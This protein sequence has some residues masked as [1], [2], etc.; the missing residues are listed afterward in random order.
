MNISQWR[1]EDIR[2]LRKVSI[3]AMD[4]HYHMAWFHHKRRGRQTFGPSKRLWQ[5]SKKMVFPLWASPSTRRHVVHPLWL[6]GRS[7]GQIWTWLEMS[8]Q[9]ASSIMGHSTIGK[10]YNI[11]PGVMA[12]C[13]RV[14]E[15]GSLTILCIRVWTPAS[16]D[17]TLWLN[18][19]T[20][21]VNSNCLQRWSL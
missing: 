9:P 5:H 2:P 14:R 6:D 4:I 8:L 19:K 1:Q 10:P 17:I 15:V 18:T 7:G 12:D 13:W 21:L 11:C 20:Y 16:A 3:L